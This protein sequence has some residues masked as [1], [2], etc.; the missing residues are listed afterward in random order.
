M[1]TLSYQEAE[2][3]NHQQTY[4]W[5]VAKQR[6]AHLE[7]NHHIRV[8][9]LISSSR[10][11][12]IA[13]GATRRRPLMERGVRRQQVSEACVVTRKRSAMLRP[14]GTQW[15]YWLHIEWKWQAVWKGNK[16]PVFSVCVYVGMCVWLSACRT[17][18]RHYSFVLVSPTCFP[19]PSNY[20]IFF[21]Y[22]CIPPVMFYSCII[23]YQPCFSM[24]TYVSFILELSFI[25]S[26]K[27][28]ILSWYMKMSWPNSI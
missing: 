5:Q 16:N 14:Q 23:F 9:C 17:D 27:T 21:I 12:Y 28:F 19:Y 8:T 24:N 2:H 15:V 4:P 20:G 25:I 11:T 13:M 10:D 1:T 26:M 6:T 18:Y 7:Q 3:I 22:H